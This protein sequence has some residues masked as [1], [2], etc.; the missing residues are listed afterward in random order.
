MSA[1][2]EI[3]ALVVELAQPCLERKL[4]CATAESCTGGMI[5]AAITD[6][7]GSSLWFDRAFV[8]YTNQAKQE[9]LGVPELTLAKFGAVSAPTAAAMV[10]GVLAHSQADLAVAVTGIAGPTGGTPDKPVGTVYIAFKRRHD[11]QCYVKRHLFAGNRDEVRTATTKE[12]LQGLKELATAQPPQ[13]QVDLS[14][15]PSYEV[16]RWPQY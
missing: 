2:P 8:T 5:S 15:L 9:M 7:S 4:V 13:N 14:P 12:A 10:N 1:C 11:S 6:L 3:A 16:V